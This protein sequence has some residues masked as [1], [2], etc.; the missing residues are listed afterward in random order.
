MTRQPGDYFAIEYGD[1]LERWVHA[2]YGWLNCTDLR[3]SGVSK[4]VAPIEPIEQELQ[5][6]PARVCIEFPHNDTDRRLVLHWQ[7]KCETGG[8]AEFKVGNDILARSLFLCGVHKGQERDC[9]RQF[10]RI[11]RRGGRLTFGFETPRLCSLRER[12][13]CA[14]VYS[15]D[16]N[17]TAGYIAIMA[18]LRAFTAAYFRTRFVA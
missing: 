1:D 8:I 15:I 10:N 9:M 18:P 14:T 6:V 2:A 16:K 7:A 12:P 3:L 4:L 11:I 13:L 5:R 17:D